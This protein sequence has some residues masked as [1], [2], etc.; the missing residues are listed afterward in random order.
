MISFLPETH[1]LINQVGIPATHEELLCEFAARVCYGS[2]DRLGSNAKFLK[3]KLYQTGHH[4]VF[5][6]VRV[7]TK[8]KNPTGAMFSRPYRLDDLV[9]L[10]NTP[11]VFLKMLGDWEELW[12]SFNLRHAINWENYSGLLG[13]LHE[14]VRWALP[15]IYGETPPL[16][17]MD[18]SKIVADNITL[19]SH[20]LPIPESQDLGSITVYAEGLSRAAANQL[21][22]HRLFSFSQESLRY[23]RP[24]AEAFVFP[25]IPENIPAEQ[26]EY[27]A[28]AYREAFAEATASYDDLVGT[29][30]VN[31]EDARAV[32]PLATKTNMVVTMPYTGLKQFLHLR[33]SKAAQFEIRA[34][35]ENVLTLVKINDPDFTY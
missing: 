4:S 9:T 26:K 19:I 15:G 32:L 7:L 28:D 31:K 24:Q 27:R 2:T 33:L 8:I 35:A 10:A 13:E 6:H 17:Y 18:A 22:R 30:K 1:L 20:S 5:E 25:P 29:L 21:V 12:V 34:F 23:V 16:S 3:A 14:Q 11:G